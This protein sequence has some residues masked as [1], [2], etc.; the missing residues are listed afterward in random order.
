MEGFIAQIILLL[1]N[2]PT[3]QMVIAY[4]LGL[5]II[6][7]C[8]RNVGAAYVKF[9]ETKSDDA[10]FNKWITKPF[11]FLTPFVKILPHSTIEL[12]KFFGFLVKGA[13]ALK[14]LF[15]DK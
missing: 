9:T 12:S 5:W 7:T 10:W 6:A 13:K 8:L 2:N 1:Q 11:S 4:A 15:P 14:K 3:A